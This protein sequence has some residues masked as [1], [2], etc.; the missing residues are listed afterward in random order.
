MDYN[1]YP[2]IPL[3]SYYLIIPVHHFMIV[4]QELG[5]I[6]IVWFKKNDLFELKEIFFFF[7]N[8][9]LYSFQ[10]NHY[11][12]ISQNNIT[13]ILKIMLHCMCCVI[14]NSLLQSAYYVV[15]FFSNILIVSHNFKACFANIKFPYHRFFQNF[16]A[17]STFLLFAHI[18]LQT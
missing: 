12:Q 17:L 18:I 3:L 5:R 1:I 6:L 15:I 14:V 10:G 16:C 11:I 2:F 8:L 4:N 9:Y 13:L 7:L